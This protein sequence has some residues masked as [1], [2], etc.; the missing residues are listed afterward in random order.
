MF[1]N[2]FFST[3][4]FCTAVSLGAA[5]LKSPQQVQQEV[6]QAQTDFEIAE[7]MF[8]PWYT[9]PLITG[10][11][12]NVPKGKF[13]L[14]PYLTLNT[15]YGIYDNNGHY[16]NTPNEFTVNPLLVFQAGI[17]EWLDI[18]IQPQGTFRFFQGDNGGGLNDL[19]VVLGFQLYNETP[20][21][22]GIRLL[23]TEVFPTGAYDRLYSILDACGKGVFQSVI[24]LNMGKTLWWMPLHPMRLRLATNLQF[25]TDKAK[26]YGLN[27]YGGGTTTNATVKVRP[28]YNLDIGYE[29]SLT[30]SWVFA[31]DFVY[32]TSGRTTLSGGTAG[33]DANGLPYPI[34]LPS[35]NNFSFAPAIEYNVADSGGLI[36]GVWFSFAGRNSGSYASAILSYT[37]LF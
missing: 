3:I 24:G 14:Q 34:G 37:Q 8:I 29:V 23:Y 4:I 32:T 30:E 11:A 17:T 20:Y 6:D 9:G 27:S 28:T 22:P 7:K 15:N 10:S 5:E 25:P 18:T 33:L 13:N 36:A 19:N 21:I 16:V 26:V 1:Y 35:S 12:K 2:K 31:L